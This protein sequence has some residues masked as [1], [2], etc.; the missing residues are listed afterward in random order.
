MTIKNTDFNLLLHVIVGAIALKKSKDSQYSGLY[1]ASQNVS[2]LS[3]QMAYIENKPT[4][5]EDVIKEEVCLPYDPSV[6]CS[7]DYAPMYNDTFKILNNSKMTVFK[8]ECGAC[9][10]SVR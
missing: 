5:K 9:I 1:L 8:G 2:T 3:Q 4:N 7:K 6:M 10:V